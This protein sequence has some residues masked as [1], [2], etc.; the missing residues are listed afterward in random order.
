M[1]TDS[2]TETPMLTGTVTVTP[3]AKRWDSHWLTVTVRGFR[4]AMRWD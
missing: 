2:L 3:T 4:W 1:Q